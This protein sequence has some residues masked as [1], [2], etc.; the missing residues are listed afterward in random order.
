MYHL[1][2]SLQ[3]FLSCS[4]VGSAFDNCNLADQWIRL[5]DCVSINLASWWVTK[6]FVYGLVGLLRK[7]SSTCDNGSKSVSTKMIHSCLFW[8]SINCVAFLMLAAVSD[9]TSC[10]L[11]HVPPRA[12]VNPANHELHHSTKKK[13]QDRK[14]IMRTST[15][16]NA[17]RSRILKQFTLLLLLILCIYHIP[18]TKTAPRNEP[19]T[20]FRTQGGEGEGGGE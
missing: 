17:E 20:L 1:D 2:Q 8:G 6:L 19:N 16:C 14:S 18:T 11:K 9:T 15:W 10:P 4:T 12:H 3:C 13:K 7:S 5:L